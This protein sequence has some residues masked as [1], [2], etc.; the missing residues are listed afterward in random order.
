MKRY[1]VKGDSLVCGDVDGRALKL[2]GYK[3]ITKSEYDKLLNAYL[4]KVKEGRSGRE[5]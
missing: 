5:S 1:F 2:K 3:E 4:E